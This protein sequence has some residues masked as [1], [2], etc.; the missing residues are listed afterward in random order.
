MY[1]SFFVYILNFGVLYPNLEF[2]FTT[3]LA[4]PMSPHSPA[5]S[6]KVSSPF[7]VSACLYTSHPP[8]GSIFPPGWLCELL[9]ILYL[10]GKFKFE[11]LESFLDVCRKLVSPPSSISIV[12]RSNHSTE[13]LSAIILNKLQPSLLL[14]NSIVPAFVSTS[15]TTPLSYVTD[16][17]ED[18]PSGFLV[19]TGS[20]LLSTR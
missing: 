15:F 20:L 12:S 8:D 5:R 19:V 10:S 18:V 3:F 16:A 13:V 2:L 1:P 7:G 14:H 11:T 9:T 17:G 6:V 4:V